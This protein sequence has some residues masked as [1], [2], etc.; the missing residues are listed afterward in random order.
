MIDIEIDPIKTINMSNS[1]PELKQ[2]IRE[3][4]MQKLVVQLRESGNQTYLRDL[5]AGKGVNSGSGS[6][7]GSIASTVSTVAVPVVATLAIQKLLSSGKTVKDATKAVGAIKTGLQTTRSAVQTGIQ[8]VKQG[9]VQ[10][11][12]RVGGEVIKQGVRQGLRT[13]ATTAVKAVGASSVAAVGATVVAGAAIGTAAAYG[14][15]KGIDSL[16]G[17]KPGEGLADRQFEGETYNPL[18][19]A[20]GFAA[21]GRSDEMIKRDTALEVA[22]SKAD[23]EASGAAQQM[24]DRDAEAKRITDKFDADFLAKGGTKEELEALIN[25]KSNDSS[26]DSNAS[27]T[28][29]EVSGN[30]SAK[31]DGRPNSGSE[32]TQYKSSFQEYQEAELGKGNSSSAP[33]AK[34]DVATGTGRKPQARFSDG[35]PIYKQPDNQS[36]NTGPSADTLTGAAQGSRGTATPTAASTGTSADTLTGAAEKLRQA[37][38]V[39]TTGSSRSKRNEKGG[40]KGQ[41]QDMTDLQSTP[42]WQK[43]WKDSQDPKRQEAMKASRARTELGNEAARNVELIDLPPQLDID[44]AVKDPAA[45]AQARRD[46][47]VIR[48]KNEKARLDARREATGQDGSTRTTKTTQ[49]GNETREEESF[50]YDAANDP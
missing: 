49:N 11:V 30:F 1:N 39:T 2:Y 22:N 27:N 6:D 7:S 38:G 12:K 10:A 4:L 40:L 5:A 17:S 35:V 16:M 34:V 13:A 43:M 20:Q 14:V 15:N 29:Q 24:R 45:A 9:G 42:A 18:K 37:G 46:R 26:S 32:D 21:L 47:G 41:S 3:Y 8:A 19:I 44:S 23:F 48:R 28:P 31:I 50:N 25:G 36:T 33:T